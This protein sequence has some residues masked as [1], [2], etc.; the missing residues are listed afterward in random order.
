ML[1]LLSL[2]GGIDGQLPADTG[3]DENSP[4]AGGAVLIVL[5]SLDRGINSQLLADSDEIGILD[6]VPLSNLLI[7]NPGATV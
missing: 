2:A 6:V 5:L 3:E 1:E 7:G 4:A